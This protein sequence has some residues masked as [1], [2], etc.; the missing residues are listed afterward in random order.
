MNSNCRLRLAPISRKTPPR[1]A[2]SS[3][4]HALRQGR[5]VVRAAPEEVV[6]I[7]GHDFVLEGIA[8]IDPADVRAEGALQSLHVIGI[9]EVVVAARV[10]SEL[11]LVTVRRQR[12]GGAAAPAA[13]HLRGNQLLFL[14]R[15]CLRPQVS[16]KRGDIHVE[17]AERHERAVAAADS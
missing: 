11:R 7:D 2:P 16:P 12:Q 3:F 13:H 5:P 17:L 10:S 1:S 4:E 14:R 15:G 9:G 6:E 8:R